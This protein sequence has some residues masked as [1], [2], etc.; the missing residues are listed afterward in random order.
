MARDRC[1]DTVVAAVLHTSDSICIFRV[2]CL[3]N[4]SVT[5]A[6]VGAVRSQNLA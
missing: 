3:K 5:W 6:D 2:P 4:G 1:G